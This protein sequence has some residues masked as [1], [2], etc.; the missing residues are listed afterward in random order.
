MQK[1]DKLFLL[2][3]QIHSDGDFYWKLKSFPEEK[4]EQGY[5]TDE[6]LIYL[7]NPSDKDIKRLMFQIADE[8][9]DSF[10]SKWN[11]DLKERYTKAFTNEKNILR[12]LNYGEFYKEY[13][14]QSLSVHFI[15]YVTKT[16]KIH[17]TDEIVEIGQFDV[18]Y[19]DL[20]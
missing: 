15:P 12:L 19:C 3:L 7:K 16:I 8:F 1:E 13:G 5:R 11:A 14:N 4:D 9:A 18:P 6:V 10:E 17:N 20:L 2:L